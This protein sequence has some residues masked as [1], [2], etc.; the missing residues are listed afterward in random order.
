MEAAAPRTPAYAS[1]LFIRA[2][3][4]LAQRPALRSPTP[5]RTLPGCRHGGGELKSAGELQPPAAAESAETGVAHA[6]VSSPRAEGHFAARSR[7]RSRC[8]RTQCATR[9]AAWARVRRAGR[10][11]VGAPPPPP[12]SARLARPASK[13]SRAA[14]AFCRTSLRRGRGALPLLCLPASSASR[15]A[16]KKRA[17]YPGLSG[18]AMPPRS[19]EGAG[20]R[21]GEAL[22][23]GRG[24]FRD[25]LLTA[26]AAG[27]VP[28][29]ASDPPGR[30]LAEE[31]ECDRA[32]EEAELLPEVVVS[33]EVVISPSPDSSRAPATRAKTFLRSPPRAD[34]G[35]G[36]G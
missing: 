35:G 29:D 12:T 7:A 16:L 20:L 14:R 18:A 28:P 26:T 21:S 32:G 10:A 17:R 25:L 6:A 31:P 4:T 8:S 5:R 22:L 9:A 19:P 11:A 33:S 24:R 36:V 13:R 34:E 23:P 30:G 15:K 27:G 2:N 3:T 1:W